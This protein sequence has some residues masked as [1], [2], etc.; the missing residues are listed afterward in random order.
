MIALRALVSVIILPVTAAVL[1][2]WLFLGQPALPEG[3]ARIGLVP[4]GVGLALF[5]WCVVLFAMRGRGTLA[6]WDPPRRFVAAGPYR[7][8][9]NPMYVGVGLVIAG[10]AILFG[11]W[12]LA[13]YLV[14]IG[15]VWHLFV[16]TYEE[17]TLEREFGE[18]YRAYRAHVPR[19][20][21][22]P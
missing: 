17:P 1:L 4:L 10:E 2:P 15:I 16:L 11:S 7:V 21:P 18:E 13:L 9:R 22:R 5:L 14:V 8:V 19:W 6:P 12:T 20:V 3:W